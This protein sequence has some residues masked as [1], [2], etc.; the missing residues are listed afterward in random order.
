MSALC[1]IKR[2]GFLLKAYMIEENGWMDPRDSESELNH[3]NLQKAPNL[4]QNI[5]RM[6]NKHEDGA[7]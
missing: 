5:Q 4:Q 6:R 7:K 3:L 1:E 2:G